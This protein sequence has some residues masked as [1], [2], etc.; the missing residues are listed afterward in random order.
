MNKR[1]ANRINKMSGWGKGVTKA[2]VLYYKKRK[3]KIA[4]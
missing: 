2:N 4:L 1:N 3:K